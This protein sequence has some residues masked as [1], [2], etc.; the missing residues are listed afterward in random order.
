[1]ENI[2][3]KNRYVVLFCICCNTFCFGGVYAWSVF[4]SELANHM[5]WNYGSVTYAYS[6]MLMAIAVTGMVGGA[7]LQRFGPRKLIVTA[8]VFWGLGW[9]LTGFSK[10]IYQL[11]ISFGLMAGAAS[12]IGYNQAVV[13]GVRWFSDKKG[14]ASGL[15]VGVA[16]VSPL[17]IAPLAN[18]L[19]DK[20]NVMIA[21]QIVGVFFLV[22]S[23]ISSWYISNP[24]VS[25]V[26]NRNTSIENA[27]SS[28]GLNWN[29]MLK[30][31]RFYLLWL[32]LLSAAISG[33]MIIG[34]A[35]KIGQEVA[36]ITPA[37]A[38]VLVG[39]M[40]VANFFGR[41]VLGT[42][43]DILGR[44]RILTAALVICAL[45]MILMSQVKNFTGFIAS[46]VIVGL[47]YGGALAVFPAI[48]S[49]V[50]GSRYSGINYGILFTAY[51]IAAIIGPSV[52]TM[53]RKSFG[54]YSYAFIFAATCCIIGAILSVIVAKINKNYIKESKDI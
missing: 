4:S 15:A 53:F 43:S 18:A 8:G 23:L 9:L 37:Q 44:Y 45:D 6:I 29:E 25:I 3:D 26:A 36:K 13:T 5:Q 28:K 16:G 12:G 48:N 1:M 33:L 49:D 42:L 50:F 39:I 38:A 22:I 19:L 21:F 34:H 7:L 27:V 11:Y 40:A 32:I 41:L 52:A 14:F 47:C 30:D 54:S 10:S 2:K 24:K 35:S 17:I 31:V 51:G 20:Y 46:M